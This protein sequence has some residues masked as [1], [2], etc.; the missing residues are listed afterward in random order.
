MR[1]C[2]WNIL[3]GG[4]GRADPIAETLI[5]QRADVL[6]LAEATDDAVVD[7]LARRTGMEALRFE[8]AN[9]ASAVLSRQPVLSAVNEVDSG[10]REFV[11][12][13]VDHHGRSMTVALLHLSAGASIGDEDRRLKEIDSVLD[14]FA[15]L[16]SQQL[17]HLLIGD[18][19][20]VGPLQR[21]DASNASPSL[22]E[23]YHRNGGRLRRDVIERVLDAGYTDTFAERHRDAAATAATFETAFPALRV[24]F[25]FA[26]NVA[27][28]DAWIEGDDLARFASDHYPIG[29]E[30]A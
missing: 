24:D 14:S 28:R 4:V 12:V 7:R 3:D 21:F 6:L 15:E 27:I 26:A 17:P 1:I 9:G 22:L 16:R 10:V 19:N 20:S 23:D 5:A 25:A 18:F 11:Q 29:V 30:L 8:S 13:T 2:F